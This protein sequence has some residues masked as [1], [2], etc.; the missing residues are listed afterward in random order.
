MTLWQALAQPYPRKITFTS[1]VIYSATNVYVQNLN[2]SCVIVDGENHLIQIQNTTLVFDSVHDIEIKNLYFSGNGSLEFRNC[3]NVRVT[4]CFWQGGHDPYKP[5]AV[6]HSSHNIEICWCGF[7]DGDYGLLV[8]NS[9]QVSIHHNLFYHN[10]ER[11]P[12]V[13]DS[14]DSEL[15]INPETVYYQVYNNVIVDWKNYALG[16]AK[17]SKADVVGNMFI[18][19]SYLFHPERQ[20]CVIM[21]GTAQRRVFVAENMGVNNPNCDL[22]NWCQVSDFDGVPGIPQHQVFSP[23]CS[24]N[25]AHTSAHRALGDVLAYV[26]PQNRLQIV[27]DTINNVKNLYLSWRKSLS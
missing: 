8:Y 7:T 26:G 15:Q 6:N 21:N 11:N 13:G 27:T 9:T 25:L 22:D 20:D 2:Q 12:K 1:D 4:N 3:Y 19:G 14:S 18:R 17:W 10:V 24:A 5:I 16:V 23:L